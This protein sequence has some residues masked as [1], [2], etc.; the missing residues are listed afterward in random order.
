[1]RTV[2]GIVPPSRKCVMITGCDFRERRDEAAFYYSLDNETWIQTGEILYMNYD[3]PDF[4]GYRYGLFA[5]ADNETKGFVDF[6]WFR[7]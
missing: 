2:H 4:T 7:F 1:M 5:Y 3:I 6:D